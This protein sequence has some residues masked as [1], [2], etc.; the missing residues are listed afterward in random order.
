MTGHRWLLTD[1]PAELRDPPPDGES[2]RE[3]VDRRARALAKGLHVSYLAA[4]EV[5]EADEQ[6]AEAERET[7]ASPLQWED[8]ARPLPVTPYDSDHALERDR[9]RAATA[10]L[11]VTDHELRAGYEAGTDVV[12]ERAQ[13]TRAAHTGS[14]RA[15]RD[16]LLMSMA[17]Q[18]LGEQEGAP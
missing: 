13:A 3:R 11:D 14:L 4:A 16:E 15:A 8:T 17:R 1:V 2:E 18:R 10:G 9:R 5:A 7:G 12:H 6:L